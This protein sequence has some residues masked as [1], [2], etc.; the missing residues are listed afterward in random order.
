M[1]PIIAPKDSSYR[2]AQTHYD[3][4]ADMADHLLLN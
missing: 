1:K 2:L 4:E 3:L